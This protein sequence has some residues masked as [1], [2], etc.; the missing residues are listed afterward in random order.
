MKLFK[1]AAVTAA[2]LSA[3]TMVS[4]D[5]KISEEM[6]DVG[7]FSRVKLEGQM[8]VEVKVGPAQSVKVV[9]DSDIIE[10]LRTRVRGSELEI[11]FKNHKDKRRLFS[12]IKKMQ[13]I[14]TVPTLE[15]AEVHGS[16]DIFVED[17]KTDRFDLKVHGSGDAVVENAVVQ[18]LRIDLHG[19]GDIEIDGSCDGVRV[20]LQ[21]SGDV[22]ARKMQ[23]KEANVALHGSGDIGVYASMAADVAVHGSGDIVVAGKPDQMRSKV[24]GSGDI[25]VR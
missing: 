3:A 5:D 20:D 23:C 21:G 12:R 7:A 19:S 14:I 15:S 4:A 9:A 24:R 11:D 6:R 8:D 17:V 16:G 2:I 25:H 18:A 22:E 1:M 13:V 10:Y